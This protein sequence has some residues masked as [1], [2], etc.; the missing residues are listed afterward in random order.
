MQIEFHGLLQPLASLPL[1]LARSRA[2]A[3]FNENQRGDEE[4]EEADD[5]RDGDELE[6]RRGVREEERERVEDVGEVGGDEEGPG[7]EDE[8]ED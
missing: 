6:V 2:T 7:E 8:D 1:T 3:E 4:Y 5:V